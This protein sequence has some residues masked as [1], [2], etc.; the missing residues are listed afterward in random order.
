MKHCAVGTVVAMLSAVCFATASEPLATGEYGTDDGMGTLVISSGSSG[1]QAFRLTAQ[2]VNGHRCGFSGTIENGIGRVDLGTPDEP[3][4]CAVSFERAGNALS[5]G[6]SVDETKWE[7]CRRRM[8]GARAGFEGS[9]FLLPAPC[10]ASARGETRAHF[11]HAFRA[12][13]YQQAAEVFE[14]LQTQCARF[15]PLRSRRAGCACAR[16]ISFPV[17]ALH[18]AHEPQSQ[19]HW[20]RGSFG[21]SRLSLA[22]GAGSVLP[23]PYLRSHHARVTPTRLLPASL[24]HCGHVAHVHLAGGASRVLG[25]LDCE[26]PIY[27]SFGDRGSRVYRFG[28]CSYVGRHRVDTRD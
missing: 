3:L 9:Y 25:R 2:G 11:L 19:G 17:R 15:V 14:R 21:P 8:C 18:C 22:V 7:Q 20:R 13:D 12:G 24:A 4:I 27:S 16:P 6:L 28:H 5:V 26:S 1:K 23:N 10:T